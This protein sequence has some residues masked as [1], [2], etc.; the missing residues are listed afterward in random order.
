[1]FMGWSVIIVSIGA[2]MAVITVVDD[3][4]MCR[5]MTVPVSSHAARN[6]FQCGL[7]QLGRRSFSGFSEK[8]TA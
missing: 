3:E 8:V 6:G 2:S 7:C 1:M 4:P 5:Q